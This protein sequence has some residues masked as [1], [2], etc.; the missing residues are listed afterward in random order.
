MTKQIE[1]TIKTEYYCKTLKKIIPDI[2]YPLVHIINQS[3]TAGVV[4]DNFKTSTI[5]PIYKSGNN[6]LLENHRP[7]SL[8]NSI[9]KIIEKIAHKQLYEHLEKNNILSTEQYGFRKHSS[10]E[11]A[12]VDLLD[13]IETNKK[14]KL[15]TNLTFIDLSKAFDTLSFDIL[16]DKLNHYNIGNTALTW[17]T[18]YLTN[19]SHKTK[20]KNAY[21]ET[22]TPQ[23][24]VPQGSILGPLLFIIYI[25]DLAENIEGTILYADDTTFITENAD[26]TKLEQDTN[27]KLENAENWFKANKLTLNEKKT[28]TMNLTGRKE[29]LTLKLRIGKSSIQHIDDNQE[30]ENAFKFL[31][32]WID[33]KLSWKHH[34]NHILNKMKTANYILTRTKHLFN[35]KTKK[36]I[37]QSLGKSHFD[38]GITIWNNNDAINKI[39]KIQKKMIRNIENLRYN[40]HTA[41]HFKNLQILKAKDII[42]LSSC[43]LVKKSLIKKTPRNIQK[44]FQITQTERPKRY[45]NNLEVSPN[46]SK[47]RHDIPK[48]WNNLPEPQKVPTY[49]LKHLK[50]DIKMSILDSYKTECTGC[51]SCS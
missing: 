39:E 43:T 17:F 24:G 22:L 5:I 3:L 26:I 30:K 50:K 7:I 13:R 35:K 23:T 42:T 49:K 51:H 16:I 31:G 46:L 48:R 29:N 14:H 10:C 19:R 6:K 12:M 37:Y 47:I 27:N 1:I 44:I 4:H 8:L 15:T 34:I 11:H 38:Y 20:Y 41:E 9:S 18:N 2:A 40:A 21:S 25:N 32:F 28:R 45:P 33:N 36:L